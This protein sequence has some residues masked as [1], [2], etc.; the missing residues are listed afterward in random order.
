V[1]RGRIK[2]RA[3]EARRAAQVSAISA[4]SALNRLR[5]LRLNRLRDLPAE[6]VSAASGYLP[7]QIIGFHVFLAVHGASCSLTPAWHGCIVS[8]NC[9]V[10]PCN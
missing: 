1:R 3:R 2:R 5:G 8:P 4:V 9:T 6:V 10:V 7:I